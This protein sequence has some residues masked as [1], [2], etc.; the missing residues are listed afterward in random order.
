MSYKYYIGIDISKE[1]FDISIFGEDAHQS[2]SND[3]KGFK[4]FIDSLTHPSNAYFVTC[5]ATGG[6]EI[7]LMT[8]L[9]EQGFA[10]HRVD[11]LKSS[12]YMRSLKSYSK[13]DMLDSEALARYG[14][15]RHESLSLFIPLE[16]DIVKLQ[17]LSTHLAGL[18][19]LR[20]SEKLRLQSPKNR[21]NEQVQS[22]LKSHIEFLNNQI[23]TIE[24]EILRII[25]GHEKLKKIKETVMQVK[26][27]G[28][29]TMLM[30]VAHCPELGKISRR[31]IASLAG[32]A[33]HPR[34]SGKQEG[35]RSTRGGRSVLR[36]ALHM[37]C[38]SA[39]RHNEAIKVFYDR[40][41]SKGK[42][43]MVAA[44]AAIRKMIVIINAKVRD[45]L[46]GKDPFA[47]GC[48]AKKSKTKRAA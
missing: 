33:P 7:D 38:L 19:K 16:E 31:Q 36:Q 6:Y 11:T 12:H 27:V 37:A 45:L 28:P 40:L 9:H 46:A 8:F 10:M 20:T 23:Q 35:Y 18:V 39:V 24:E 26:G 14:K 47:V 1:K 29:K 5:E 48:P 41:I 43:K 42:K 4:A 2:F 25:N 21:H 34:E 17:A 15:E 30:L 13:S 22:S 44:V 32:V 3:A